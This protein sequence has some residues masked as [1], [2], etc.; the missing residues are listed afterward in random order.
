M[1][2]N[3]N[4]CFEWL[5]I[6]EGGYVNNP[7]D[8]GGETNL[9]VTKKT[10]LNYCEKNNITPKD[11]HDLTKQDVEPIYRTEYWDAIMGESLPSGLDWSLF[12]FA[13]NSGPARASEYIQDSV[14]VKP[15]GDI[16]PVTLAAIATHE[17]DTLIKDIYERRQ[18]FYE[19][20][21][22]FKVFGKGWTKQ[23]KHTEEQAF[24]LAAIE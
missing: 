9:G 11:M 12:D 20:L 15:D 17:T 5:L 24:Q 3:F 7:E 8:T 6:N 2:I 4:Q 18:R 23:D 10:Y 16:G 19:S 1:N 21:S 14:S 13:V 22:T